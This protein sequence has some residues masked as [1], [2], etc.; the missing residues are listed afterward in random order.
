MIAAETAVSEAVLKYNAGTLRAY[1]ELCTTIGVKP[2]QHAL[3][4]AEEK[5]S[6][7]RQKRQRLSK[8]EARWPSDATSKRTPR[9]TAQVSFSALKTM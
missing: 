1:T 8:H 6:T 7:A 9:A 5:D 2:G 3:Q 4:R